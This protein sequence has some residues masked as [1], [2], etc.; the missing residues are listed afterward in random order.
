MAT[1]TAASRAIG[2]G[3][4]P[5]SLPMATGFPLL[6]FGLLLCRSGE[7]SRLAELIRPS[8]PFWLLPTAWVQDLYTSVAG[9][10]AAG[11]IRT[12][13][14]ADLCICF[15]LALQLRRAYGNA[16]AGPGAGP[17]LND[18]REAAR[19]CHGKLTGA[20]TFDF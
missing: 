19:T 20:Q 10:A 13:A 4:S 2:H 16:G 5:M 1:C 12:G 17:G 3:H 8:D 9:I 18:D 7:A 11:G 15:A 6:F 14:G